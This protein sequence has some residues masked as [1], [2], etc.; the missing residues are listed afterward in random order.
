MWDLVA[1]YSSG[2][3]ADFGAYDPN[4]VIYYLNNP[5]NL[6]LQD[7]PFTVTDLGGGNYSLAFTTPAGTCTNAPDQ[8]MGG[9]L[10]I[11]WSP[12]VIANS[13]G[14][15]SISPSAPG[16]L[17]GF[18]SMYAQT[19]ALNPSTYSTWFSANNIADPAATPGVRQQV[20]VAAGVTG[21]TTANFSVK[22]LS[23]SRMWLHLRV[24][25]AN[26]V[27]VSGNG[28]T[29]TVGSALST[30]FTV[31]VTDASGNPVSG[32]TVTFAVTAG[33]GTLSATVVS[34]NA[35]GLASTTLTLGATA[36]TNTV[37]ASSGTLAGSPVS[38]TAT[39]VVSSTA[40]N[41][42]SVSGNG[43][44]GTVGQ[45]LATPFT[46]K[47]TDASGNPVS[48][49]TVNFAVT[50][51][52]GTLSSTVV[53]SN[54]SGLASSTLTLGATPGANTVTASSGTLA[55]SPVAFSAT[56]VGSTASS[57][58]L[59]SGNGQ[60]GTA[61]QALANPFTAKV[62]DASGN[63]V[64]GVAVTFAVTGG[65]GTLSATVVSTNASG[66]ASTTLTLGATSGTNTVTASSAALAGSPL[67]FTATGVS[68]SNG[69]ITWTKQPKPPGLP[70][71]LG[72]LTL[73]FDPLSQQTLLFANSGGIYSSRNCSLTAR[74]PIRSH[75]FQT[76]A[77][78]AMCVADL[79]N[80]PWEPAPGRTDGHRYETQ[81]A[82]D[83]WRR[84]PK[85]P[86]AAYV[87]VNGT[88]VVNLNT[89]TT[90]WLFP[91]GGQLVG[92]R[93][94]IG[95]VASVQQVPLISL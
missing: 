9:C 24:Q 22:A 25:R 47:V 82:V 16:G 53:S 35:S 92:A 79:P 1:I 64:A 63:P 94:S 88:R 65:G 77:P 83:L 67:T 52:G 4:A 50:A 28:Q 62:A 74:L 3:A 84:K 71:W 58:V 27:G 31:K 73:P 15:S 41:L 61:G 11:K 72:W 56:A 57:L 66:L 81:C 36:G 89:S 8:R 46:V 29:G 59:M 13:G 55:G 75:L 7:V 6:A 86:G 17:L 48:G 40:T 33:G 51:G 90:Q 34:S 19:F 42:V 14:A 23:P 12:K 68:G 54:A 30:P 10:R 21:L 26:L 18:D 60:S 93:T 78:R 5:T 49:T 95:T 45:A 87:N 76:T 91:T 38:F 2:W 70:G 80:S 39:A 69:L 43:Q 44:S 20:T 85:L 32:I 37:T